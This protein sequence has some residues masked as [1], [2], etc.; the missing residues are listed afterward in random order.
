MGNDSGGQGLTINLPLFVILPRKRKKDKKYYLNLNIYRNTH[1]QVLNQAKYAYKEEVRKS[2]MAGH[3]ITE[4]PL[5]LRYTLY[6]S[7]KRRIDLTNVISVI[8]KFTQDALVELGIIEDDSILYIQRVT[9][10]F[11]GIN[12]HNPRCVLDIL[13]F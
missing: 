8:D 13:Q 12:K 1:F 10:V 5:E 11:G 6:V 7:T 3:K 2:L 9:A 4:Y